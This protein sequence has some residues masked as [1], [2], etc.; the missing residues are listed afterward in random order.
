MRR[1]ARALPVSVR[2][3]VSV[4]VP[5][6]V[7]VPAPVLVPAPSAGLASIPCPGMA[8]GFSLICIR[9]R[10]NELAEEFSPECGSLSVIAVIHFDH[11]ETDGVGVRRHG[12]PHVSSGG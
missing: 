9:V 10:V 4:S 3:S 6:F 7:S 2:S 1:N 8:L 5:V 11:I 12:R